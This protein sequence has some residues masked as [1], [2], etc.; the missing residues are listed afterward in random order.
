MT[1]FNLILFNIR[2]TLSPYSLSQLILST[3]T[4]TDTATSFAVQM[5]VQ[6]PFKKIISLITCAGSNRIEC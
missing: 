4:A 2:N 6:M 3:D 5:A 1:F